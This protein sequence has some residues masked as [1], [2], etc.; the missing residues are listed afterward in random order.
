MKRRENDILNTQS[1]EN[2]SF[3]TISDKFSQLLISNQ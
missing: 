3:T 1:T 2:Q